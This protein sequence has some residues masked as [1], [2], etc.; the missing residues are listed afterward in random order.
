LIEILNNKPEFWPH[1]LKINKLNYILEK[2]LFN[3]SVEIKIGFI[4]C[5][6]NSQE[7]NNNNNNMKTMLFHIKPYLTVVPTN[8][9][10]LTN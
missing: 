6:A 7:N 4:Q 3:V 2:I 1:K 10:A 8:G 9:L 5:Q